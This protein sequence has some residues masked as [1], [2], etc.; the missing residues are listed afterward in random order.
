VKNIK[1]FAK[2]EKEISAEYQAKKIKIK[3]TKVKEVEDIQKTRLKMEDPIGGIFNELE[4]KM[5]W[6]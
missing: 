4:I 5:G 1:D 2:K 6:S 3:L